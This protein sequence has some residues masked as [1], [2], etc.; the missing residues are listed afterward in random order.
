MLAVIFSPQD[1]YKIAYKV[2]FPDTTDE[3]YE[4]IWK[5][6]D[7]DGDGNLTVK[8][9]AT[10]MGEDA[11]TFA[12]HTFFGK[13]ATFIDVVGSAHAAAVA[14]QQMAEQAAT[15]AALSAS[16][17]S[18]TSEELAEKSG[19]DTTAPEVAPATPAPPK[20]PV[21]ARAG[22]KLH[23]LDKLRKQ[24]EQAHSVGEIEM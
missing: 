20:L 18:S 8:E 3:A 22:R 7:A 16:A 14:R 21:T 4:G 23:K 5:K 6:M 2:M 10:Y 19:V 1:E 15:V 9:L 13:L 24:Q 17:V 12:H 11:S